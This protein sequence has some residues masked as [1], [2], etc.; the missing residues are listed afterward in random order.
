MHQIAFDS[1]KHYTWASVQ[2]PTGTLLQEGRLEHRAGLIRSFLQQWDP[3]SPVALETIGNWY[4]IVNEIEQAG[5]TPC[6]VHARKAKIMMGL[7][8][9]TDKL[10]ARGMN[11]LQRTGTLPT[12]WIP[13]ADLRD[14]RELPRTRMVLAQ[15]RTRLKNR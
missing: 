15:E 4:W 11:R 8:N 13:P 6:L 1:H 14:Q 12:V 9:K 2:T 5:M 7:T 3:G 10:D